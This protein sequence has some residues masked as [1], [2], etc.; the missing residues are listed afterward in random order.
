MR[1]QLRQREKQ[2]YIATDIFTYKDKWYEKCKR[3]C[4]FLG[5]LNVIIN[6]TTYVGI[7]W[8]S[9]RFSSRSM[10]FFVF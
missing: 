2:W 5:K 6:Y 8:Y 1:S 3:D 9:G 4:G 7:D 10:I